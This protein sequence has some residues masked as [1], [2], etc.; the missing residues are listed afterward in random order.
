[1]NFKLNPWA[2]GPIAALA[3]AL[4]VVGCGGGGGSSGTVA[5]TS[6]VYSG[7]ITGF[8]SVIV[9]G[10]RFDTVG[11][12][13]VDDDGNPVRLDELRLGMMVTVGGDAD[14]ATSRGTATQLSLTHGTT[15]AITSIDTVAGTLVLLGQTVTTNAST[16]YEGVATFGDLI[17]G[18]PIE[19]YGVLQSDNTLLA[20]L[21]EKKSALSGVRLVGYMSALDTITQTFV[22]GGL[23]VNYAAVS[24]APSG[25]D[26]GKRV[27]IRATTGPDLVT[28]VLTAASVK[29][30]EGAANGENVA[31]NSYLKLKGIAETAPVNGLLKVSGT[32]VD[33]SAA[34]FVGGSSIT[35]G[36]VIKVKGIWDGSVLKATKVQVG[37]DDNDRNELYGAVSSL[38]TV[39]STTTVVV[40]D[41]TVD[42][43]NAV[44]THGSLGQLA[45][46]SYV[47]IKG[48]VV[49]GVLIATKVEL[50]TGHAAA[51]F[52][53][54]DFGVISD[55]T[56]ASSFKVNGVAVDASA[57]RFAHGTASDLA[58]G[59]YVEIEGAQNDA[60]VFVATK[61]E[62][63]A[64]PV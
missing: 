9:N 19:V 23:T 57:A 6:S 26:N 7:P 36:Q 35:A 18:D 30:N 22:V 8:G 24:P 42:V 64:P 11:A 54:E 60:G 3:V 44:F 61:V 33:V 55:F 49:D 34:T 59:A 15:G 37:A 56:S 4:T 10:V 25:L 16:I 20:T 31:A 27:K 29:V 51:G 62:F 1:M 52:T 28:G 53:F 63:K 58:D 2:C 40:H 39:G 21:I 17:V 41:V 46:G 48:H 47:E 12:N 50:K 43:S 14:D 5:P 45:V 32:P 13:T 38:T